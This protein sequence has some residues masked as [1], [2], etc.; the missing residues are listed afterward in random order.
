MFLSDS[1]IFT[2]FLDITLLLRILQNQPPLYSLTCHSSFWP[3][4]IVT[5]RRDSRVIEGGVT[6]SVTRFG[7]SNV[8]NTTEE[9]VYSCDIRS[10][11]TSVFGDERGR[12]TINVTSMFLFNNH[13]EILYVLRQI[14]SSTYPSLSTAPLPPTNLTVTQIGESTVLVSWTPAG[15][16]SQYRISYQDNE[17]SYVTTAGPDDSSVTLTGLLNDVYS[18]SISARTEL[19]SD[20]VGPVNISLSEFKTA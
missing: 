2:A 8:L 11:S 5:W 3:S 1:I 13:K 12:K 4:T 18:F 19:S 7:Y 15:R 10:I 20:E 6:T 9:G 14:L 16:P 17:Q